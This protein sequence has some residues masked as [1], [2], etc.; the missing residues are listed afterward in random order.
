[1]SLSDVI[2]RYKYEVQREEKMFTNS[3]LDPIEMNVS[4]E[5]HIFKS[6]ITKEK[7]L[8]DIYWMTS[9][10]RLRINNI[11]KG[12]YFRIFMEKSPSLASNNWSTC[13]KFKLSNDVLI[14][15]IINIEGSEILKYEEFGD[16]LS[17]VFDKDLHQLELKFLINADMQSHGMPMGL[18]RFGICC[19]NNINYTEPFNCVLESKF[20]VDMDSNIINGIHLKGC[21]DIES[22]AQRAIT[23]FVEVTRENI[24]YLT[25][26]IKWTVKF[27]EILGE[28]LRI[29]PSG[30][31]FKEC[32]YPEAH[33]L[34]FHVIV[35]EMSNEF[36]GQNVPITLLIDGK[37]IDSSNVSIKYKGN[38]NE[39][40]NPFN[41]HCKGDD[42]RKVQIDS[43]FMGT[44]N[45]IFNYLYEK[46]SVW[47]FAKDIVESWLQRYAD[48]LT[49]K[50]PHK[51]FESFLVFKA[52]RYKEY[53]ELDE[54]S[55][56][57]AF[58]CVVDRL[59]PPKLLD[60]LLNDAEYDVNAID[61]FGC[62]ALHWS[63]A[64][65]YKVITACLIKN[66][67]SNEVNDKLFNFSPN[68]WENVFVY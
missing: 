51:E 13:S 58:Y 24:I 21:Y 44:N 39:N 11:K 49:G 53:R 29:K 57:P 19:C 42:K 14:K 62:T 15:P 50:D 52:R 33:H 2:R 55:R 6:Y 23:L 36:I 22:L 65:D 4:I 35:P 37:Y 31:K 54:F 28:I 67:A 38:K 59:C 60:L 26:N 10:I 47:N 18:L 63:K 66:G 41:G 27:G 30:T 7:L 17:F 40:E 25:P 43:S 48:N 16:Y 1:M 68:Q 12:Y 61:N 8:G 64:Y 3:Q 46:G 34:I 32:K 20:K 9:E 45:V 5:D 56:N